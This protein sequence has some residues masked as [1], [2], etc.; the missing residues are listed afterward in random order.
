MNC[1]ASIGLDLTRYPIVV[2]RHVLQCSDA[3]TKSV[4]GSA[5]ANVWLSEL[6][7]TDSHAAP[8]GGDPYCFSNPLLDMHGKPKTVAPN[9]HREDDYSG[10]ATPLVIA[11]AASS[12]RH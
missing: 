8:F 10:V 3:M 9:G 4:C 7:K 1:G 2:T 11:G 12:H 5:S 6:P